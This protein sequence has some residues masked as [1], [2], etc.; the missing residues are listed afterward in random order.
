MERLRKSTFRYIEQEIY[1]YHK[2][3]RE[4]EQLVQDII[5][6]SPE[7]HEI[8]GTDISDPTSSSALLLYDHKLRSRISGVLSTI[9]HAFHDLPHNQLAVLQDKYWKR[10]YLTWTTIAELHFVERRTLYNWRTALVVEIA[11]SL[12]MH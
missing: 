1:D 2:T 10:S 11:K 8:R 6:K 5:F 4:F 3:K 7:K 9:D 12:G